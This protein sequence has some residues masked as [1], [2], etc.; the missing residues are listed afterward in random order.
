MFSVIN[1][2]CL[3]MH[4]KTEAKASPRDFQDWA[5]VDVLRSSKLCGG[6]CIRFDV[7]V[8]KKCGLKKSQSIVSKFC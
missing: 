6:L 2:A 7:V 4:G 3:T 5:D 1:R 8:K